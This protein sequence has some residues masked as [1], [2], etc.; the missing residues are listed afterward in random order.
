[1]IDE[2]RPEDICHLLEKHMICEENQDDIIPPSMA[3]Y[4][5]QEAPISRSVLSPDIKH[6]IMICSDVKQ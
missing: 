6:L 3:S 4:L 2:H 1:M 5:E